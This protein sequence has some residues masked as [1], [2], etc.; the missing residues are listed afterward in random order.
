MV[1]EGRVGGADVLVAAGPTRRSA[2]AWPDL[3]QA[4]FDD[5]DALP[6]LVDRAFDLSTRTGLRQA[7]RAD[8]RAEADEPH[9]APPLAQHHD[10]AHHD[11]RERAEA[12]RRVE[13]V[14]LGEHPAGRA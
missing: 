6:V 3:P 4:V 8:D 12:M 14:G 7:E 2:L 1:R 10:D 13:H 5:L 11:Q 9:R